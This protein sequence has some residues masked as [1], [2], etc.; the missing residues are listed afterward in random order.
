MN[1]QVVRLLEREE[2]DRVVDVLRQSAFADGK[3]TAHGKAREV[4]HNLQLEL[5]KTA[6]SEIENLVLSAL[7]RNTDFQ[8][9]A[10]PKRVTRPM[11]SRYDPG[12]QYGSHIDNAMMGGLNGVRTDFA[13]TLF[14]CPPATYDGGELVIERPLGEEEIKLDAGEAIVYS[15]SSVHH[16]APVTRGSRLAA[17]GWVQSIVR[18]D[19]LREILYDL[20]RSSR[21]AEE[22]GNSEL[23]LLLGK[24]YHNLLRY[25][26]EP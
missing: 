2:L 23:S 13:F 14:L 6:P 21:Q 19:R 8:G 3:L 17:V 20:A 25:A 15:A 10:L 16:V 26:A 11:F 1:Y 9:F 24:S 5:G 12:M 22:T 18:D 4:K 7:T